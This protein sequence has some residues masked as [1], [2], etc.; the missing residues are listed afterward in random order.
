MD[1]HVFPIPIPPPTSL[2]T[3]SL[4]VFPV[5]QV[6]TLVSCIQPGLVICFTWDNIHVS[7]LANEQ[8]CDSFRSTVEVLS[9]TYTCIH[10][11]PT[12]FPSRLLH[13]IEQSSLCYTV[14]PCW[15]SILNIPADCRCKLWKW[16][17]AACL[18]QA[19]HCFR[20]YGYNTEK[21]GPCPHVIPI[22]WE[23]WDHTQ[24]LYNTHVRGSQVL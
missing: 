19:S 7:M 8:C 6:R 14:D 18:S 11:P 2:S 5:H 9:H 12:P 15:L 20:C 24:V 17:G 13:N 4:W 3:R 21:S 23:E 1:L 22:Q 10:S 16:Q